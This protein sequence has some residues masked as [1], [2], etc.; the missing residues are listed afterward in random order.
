MNKPVLLLLF[1]STSFLHPCDTEHFWSQQYEYSHRKSFHFLFIDLWCR[2]SLYH[3]ATVILNVN[4]TEHYCR[5]QALILVWCTV[6][7]CLTLLWL[8]NCLFPSSRVFFRVFV[9]QEW[10]EPVEVSGHYPSFPAVLL[11]SHACRQGVPML[12][13]WEDERLVLPWAEEVQHGKECL[14]QCWK[15]PAGTEV[16]FPRIDRRKIKD[17]QRYFSKSM[18][19]PGMFAEGTYSSLL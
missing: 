16:L 12:C 10:S 13:M 15:S 5:H 18:L 14:L 17:S 9:N 7:Y 11:V 3:S 6:L 1:R 4:N 8:Q 2:T 19:C